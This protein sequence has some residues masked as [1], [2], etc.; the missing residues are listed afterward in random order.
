MNSEL[1]YE[2]AKHKRV[3]ELKISPKEQAQV[4]KT[5]SSTHAICLK[6]LV[7]LVGLASW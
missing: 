2:E 6:D 1:N 7:S 3:F 5:K 4:T